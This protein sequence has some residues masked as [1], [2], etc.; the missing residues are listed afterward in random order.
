M[1]QC[2]KRK[3]ELSRVALE[4]GD[5][6][7]YGLLL[8]EHWTMKRKRSSAISNPKIDRWHEVGLKNGAFGGKL[9]GA[10]GAGFLM[11][12]AQDKAKLRQAM[13]DEGLV[14]I[15]FRFDNEGTRVLAE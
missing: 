2:Y 1:K 11:F 5:L 15:R 13:R 9:V 7:S 3:F 4:K 14:E 8:S 6:P 10:G 12:C